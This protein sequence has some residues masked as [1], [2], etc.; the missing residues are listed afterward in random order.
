MVLESA[1]LLVV[2][3]DV[4][5][6]VLLGTTRER[7]EEV[8]KLQDLV[9]RVDFGDLRGARVIGTREHLRL[10]RLRRVAEGS[11][12][13]LLAELGSRKATGNRKKGLPVCVKNGGSKNN[14]SRS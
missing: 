7:V 2:Y 3:P 6:D 8:S 10:Q 14:N 12:S 4:L 1:D 9:L 5:L 13:T 11:R